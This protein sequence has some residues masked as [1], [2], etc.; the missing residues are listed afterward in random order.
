MLK[1]VRDTLR[2]D[3]AIANT[4]RAGNSRAVKIATKAEMYDL[5]LSSVEETKEQ[6]KSLMAQ[7]KEGY[8]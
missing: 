6:V 3:H 2:I 7:L 4:V 5:F 8:A 1:E